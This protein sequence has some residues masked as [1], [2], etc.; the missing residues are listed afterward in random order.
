MWRKDLADLVQYVARAGLTVALTPSGT[1]M[2]TPGRLEELKEAGLSRIAVSLDGPDP[3]TH[4]AFRRVR[5]SYAN[6]LKI[7]EATLKSPAPPDQLHA[8]PSNAS[9]AVGDGRPGGRVSLTLWAVFFLVQTG[10]GAS[11]EQITAAECEGVLEF[12]DALA[13][14]APF[15]IKTTEAPHYRRFVRRSAAGL[16]VGRALG[17]RQLRAPRAV[18]DGNG[19]VFVDHLG[20]I[21]PSGFLPMQR[22]TSGKAALSRPTA[23]TRSSG[24]CAIPT[25][26]AA[27]VAAASSEPPAA[28]RVPAPTPPPETPLPRTR[29]VSTSRRQRWISPASS[30]PR[31]PLNTARRSRLDP[32]LGAVRY[33][34]ALGRKGG[35]FPVRSLTLKAMVSVFGYQCR[36]RL[37][38]TAGL[39]TAA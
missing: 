13:L 22:E 25:L 15:G 8:E 31:A 16:A 19:F 21:C 27:A 17:R 3:D 7:I 36:R 37:E 28:V 4:D 12:L 35:R 10:R 39:S 9:H 32:C 24:A 1:A 6:T 38:A 26:A 18:N 20:N 34:A 11:V 29:C 23:M 5:G 33:S 2:A 30:A 14:D